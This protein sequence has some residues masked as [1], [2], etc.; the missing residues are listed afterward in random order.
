MN[1]N[2]EN[3]DNN[4]NNENNEPVQPELQ[5]EPESVEPVE[6]EQEDQEALEPEQEK[7]P[8]AEKKPP[9]RFKRFLRKALI[10]LAIIAV[11]FLAGALTYH[12]V[13][14]VPL[15]EALEETRAELAQANDEVSALQRENE[16]LTTA[17]QSAEREVADLEEELADATANLKFY[18]V[19]VNVSTAR[20]ELFLENIEGAQTA[21]T[22]TQEN[23]DELLPFIEEV[24]PELAL[25]L[26]RRLELIISGLER[27]PETARVDLELLTKDLL[28]LEPLLVEE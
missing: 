25:S 12:F 13:R 20:L 9:S 3:N 19:L 28:E 15:S 7:E 22:E 17:Y 16:R 23:L 14:Y 27:D 26:P 4:V 18:Q 8:R 2:S 21:L 1:E 11:I 6:T 10:G 24:D 5:P